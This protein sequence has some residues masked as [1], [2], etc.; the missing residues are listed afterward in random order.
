MSI[1]VVIVALVA[2][3]QFYAFATSGSGGI[4]N[5]SSGNIHLWVAIG[6]SLLA[7]TAGFMVFWAAVQHDT[8]DELHITAPPQVWKR[9]TQ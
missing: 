8:D 3:Q 9:P 4:G 6:L 7:C 2:M 5:A 1:G